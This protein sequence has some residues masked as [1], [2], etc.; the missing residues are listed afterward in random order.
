MIPLTESQKSSLASVLP[1]LLGKVGRDNPFNIVR[2]SQRKN[3]DER[4]RRGELQREDQSE[5]EKFQEMQEMLDELPSANRSR[6]KFP[7]AVPQTNLHKKPA[8][9]LQQVS[10]LAFLA[11]GPQRANLVSN[12]ALFQQN[13]GM[14]TSDPDVS[15]YRAPPEKKSINGAPIEFRFNEYGLTIDTRDLDAADDIEAAIKEFLGESTVVQLPTFFELKYRD[16]Q[17]TQQLLENTLG[18]SDGSGGGDAGGNPLGG[19]MN[20][21]VPGG[22]LLDG[23]LGDS[24]GS[25]LE[26]GLEGDVRFTVDVRFNTLIVIGATGNDL[27]YITSLIDHWDRPEA[28]TK[29]EVNGRTRTIKVF[30]RD[31]VELVDII[32]AQLPEMIYDDQAQQGKQ[33][34][35]G[36]EVAQMMKAVQALQGGKGGGGGGTTSSAGG[37]KQTVKLGVDTASSLILVTGPESLYEEILAIVKDLDVAPGPRVTELLPGSYS[38]SLLDALLSQFEG[39]LMLQSSSEDSP[40][41]GANQKSQDGS[42]NEKQTAQDRARQEAIQRA[43]SEANRQQGGR[44]GRGGA[45][46]AGGRGGANQGGRGGATGGRGGATGGRGGATGGRGGATTGGGGGRGGAT[47]GRGGR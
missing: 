10:A 37:E 45:N 31:V 2:P 32:K 24:G 22:D 39:K 44:G 18:L 3:I 46:Q 36:G 6:S 38:Q 9:A 30:H 41:G 34:A 13:D 21:L 33:G 26:S 19:I 8:S 15:G 7:A 17:E 43:F 14:A 5:D 20:N 35:G 29:A 47:G 1:D 11:L 27:S 42:G 16:A 25:D 23:L 12:L 4:I 28:E 40:N